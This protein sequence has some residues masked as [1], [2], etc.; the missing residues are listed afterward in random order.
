MWKRRSIDSIDN[1]SLKLNTVKK[2]Q[3]KAIIK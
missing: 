2:I 3:L 1:I